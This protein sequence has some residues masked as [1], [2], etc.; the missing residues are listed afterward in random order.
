MERSF[1]AIQFFRDVHHVA[2]LKRLPFPIAPAI[3]RNYAREIEGSS[4]GDVC[5]MALDQFVKRL[6]HPLL[7]FFHFIHSPFSLLTSAVS[8]CA[9]SDSTSRVGDLRSVYAF[10]PTPRSADAG[11]G[12]PSP[13]QTADLA[14]L[15]C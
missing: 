1:T 14:Q 13:P 7:H 4:S 2:Q 12:A 10:L 8:P 6:Q 15:P 3:S 11:R 9:L 5:V